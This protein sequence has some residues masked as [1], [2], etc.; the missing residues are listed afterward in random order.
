MSSFIT[1]QCS[2]FTHRSSVTLRCILH[3]S[4]LSLQSS[5]IGSSVF[6]HASLHSSLLAL[7]SSFIGLQSRFG[8]F[9]THHSSV[10]SLHS[11][12]F[13]DEVKSHAPS[14]TYKR[15]S[16][17][18]ARYREVETSEL[19]LDAVGIAPA[20]GPRPRLWLGTGVRFNCGVL[21]KY[22]GYCQWRSS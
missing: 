8:A 19:D 5:L 7:Q 9:F 15:K 11:S 18:A 2:V 3:S 12:V 1:L 22:F 6:C 17:A 10:F 4:L 16:A 13:N 14:K 21:P 20:I